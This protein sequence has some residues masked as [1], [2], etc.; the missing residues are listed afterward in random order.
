MR[1]GPLVGGGSADVQ[2]LELGLPDGKTDRV[3]VRQHGAADWK[4]LDAGVTA[5]EH[6]LLEA[7]AAEGLP[8]PRPRMC[9][10]DIRIGRPHR[11]TLAARTP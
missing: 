8:V 5:H 1:S 3:V 11:L 9:D 6:A 2:G 7:L 4:A 10:L